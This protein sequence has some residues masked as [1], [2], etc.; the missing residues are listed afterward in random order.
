MT[1]NDKYSD[2]GQTQVRDIIQK[3]NDE[4]PAKE[5]SRESVTRADGSKAVRVV[6]KRR[7]LVSEKDKRRRSRR[8]FLFG[9]F[10]SMLALAC[11]LLFFLWNMYRMSSQASYESLAEDLREE[12]GAE[13]IEL[14]GLDVNGFDL[15]IDKLVLTFPASSGSM[16]ESVVLHEVKGSLQKEGVFFNDYI[17]EELMVQRALVRLREGAD[18]MKPSDLH[19]QSFLEV[20]QLV[21]PDF[22]VIVGDSSADSIFTVTG[23]ELYLRYTEDDKSACSLTFTGGSF[24]LRSWKKFTIKD[25]RMLLTPIG[26]E[27]FRANLHLP[28]VA[29]ATVEEGKLSPEL[30]VAADIPNGSSIYS[31]FGIDSKYM[32]LSDFTDARLISFFTAQTRPNRVE[33]VNVMGAQMSL[34]PLGGVPSFRGEFRLQNAKWKNIPALSV[35]MSHLP[36]DRRSQYVQLAITHATVNL[37]STPE[38]I[39]MNFTESDMSENYSVTLKGD[40]HLDA[41]HVLNGVLSYGIPAALTRAEYPDGVSDPVFKEIGELAWL[42]TKLTGTTFAPQDDA[43]MQDAAAA[44]ARKSRPEPYQI[45][46]LDFEKLNESLE[47]LQ[48]VEQGVTPSSG[49]SSPG[50]STDT[51]SEPTPTGGALF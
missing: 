48:K 47:R 29:A 39:R 28:A 22:N 24:E 4:K 19:D 46:D 13:H 9:V 27:D 18:E 12:W 1:S 35:I 25:A 8:T 14:V 32:Q 31:S 16:V 7:V 45:N 36:A 10:L 34:N 33:G 44:E 21:C 30:Y 23:T 37:D 38:E 5:S 3:I 15:V 49:T 6:R 17:F 42:D 26:M 11:M 20:R 51:P 41:Q 50:T 43:G 40:I 2:S